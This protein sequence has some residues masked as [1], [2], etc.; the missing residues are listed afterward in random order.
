[1]NGPDGKWIGLGIGDV[2][3]KIAEIKAFMRAKFA[4]YCG[5]LNDSP[6][7]GEPLQAAVQ[8]MQRRYGLPDTGII[9]Y[10]T[11]VKMGFIKKPPPTGPSARP[12]FFSVEGHLSNMWEGP[13]A[14]TGAALEREGH[15]FHQPIGYNCGALPFDNAS[16]SNELARMFGQGVLDSGVPFPLGT[17]YILA[18]FSQGAI[19]VTDFIANFL[20]PGQVHDPRAKDCLGVL[21]YGNPCRSRGSS[22]PW[23]RG[24]AGPPQNAGLDPYTR[25]DVLGISPPFPVMDV[26]RKGDIFADN[27]PGG[28][29]ELKS[30]VYQAVARMDLF[31][32]P[33]SLV[34]QIAEGFNAPMDFVWE[35]FQA[36][37]SGV[38][39]LAT[40]PSPHYAPYNLTGGIDW[41]RGLLTASAAA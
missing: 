26:Y 40:K 25:L 10:A 3:P 19:V 38:T 24:L 4:S 35:I 34:A 27:E 7:F 8:E 1:M 23:S 2:D 29:G 36:I 16:G 5:N 20:Q 28:V 37:V 15:C 18:G 32:N 9:N 21:M 30:A 39:F 17:K 6:V 33:Y 41:A 14:D 31:S 22:A 12:L 11:Q 13:V